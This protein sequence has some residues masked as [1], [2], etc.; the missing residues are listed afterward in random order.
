MTR[1]EIAMLDLEK[2]I[3]YTAWVMR[4]QRMTPR[5]AAIYHNGLAIASRSAE[6]QHRMAAERERHERLRRGNEV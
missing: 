6:A 5:E 2:E 1:L 4:H 3:A